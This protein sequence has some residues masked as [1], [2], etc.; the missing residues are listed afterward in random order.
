VLYRVFGH[1][2][3]SY[4]N[5]RKKYD[6]FTCENI[7]CCKTHCHGRFAV[8][9][10]EFCLYSLI[11]RKIHGCLEIPDLFLVHVEHD[12]SLVRCTHSWDIM[13]NTRNKSG[14]SALPCIILYIV[15]QEAILKACAYKKHCNIISEQ[16]GNSFIS[17]I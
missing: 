11:N 3:K 9:F 16:A 6:I 15:T 5:T 7:I 2:E 4:L 17:E 13:F 8:L 1:W 14:I 10:T 12:I